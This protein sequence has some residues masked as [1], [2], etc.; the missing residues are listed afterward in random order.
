MES[1]SAPSP[2]T[3]VM[4]APMPSLTSRH[5]LVAH[6]PH[7]EDVLGDRGVGLDLGPQAPDVDVD[8]AA[9]AEVVVAPD[10]VEQLLAAEHLV[11]AG[12]ELAQE[13][14][15]RP[16]AV[17]LFAVQ[18]AQHALLGEQLEVAESE[19]TGLLL[20]GPGAPQQRADAGRELLGHE[21]LGD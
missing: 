6:A 2:K 17:D 16:G 13:A 18:P 14:E 3:A 21:G 7:G 8:E 11:G 10:A 5:Q 12:R 4:R 1:R 19:G 15:L 9:V 20:G